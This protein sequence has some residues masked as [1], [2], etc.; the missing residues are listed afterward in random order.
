MDGQAEEVF[1]N[2]VQSLEAVPVGHMQV[3]GPTLQVVEM[4]VEPSIRLRKEA[5]ATASASMSRRSV[6]DYLP[7]QPGRSDHEIEHPLHTRGLSTGLLIGIE[8]DIGTRT[9]GAF[10]ADYHVLPV[11][12][13][14]PVAGGAGSP[15]AG[16]PDS[17]PGSYVDVLP[18]IVETG[19]TIDEGVF[20]MD[21]WGRSPLSDVRQ[22]V[23]LVDPGHPGPSDFER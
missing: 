3:H 8:F 17:L 7:P 16:P 1:G 10:H 19:T 6:F 2:L 18:L 21:V 23:D 9:G 22:L 11:H 15:L 12:P 4:F 5:L 14:L 20:G 13:Q